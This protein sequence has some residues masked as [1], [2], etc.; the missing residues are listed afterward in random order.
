[1]EKIG[2]VLSGG[3]AKGAYQIGV[4]KALRK[5]K[6]KYDVVTG[7][8]AGALN[9]LLFVQ[10]EYRKAKKIWENIDYNYVFNNP[11]KLNED[12]DNTYA[13]YTTYFNE[14]IKNGGMKVEK[15]EK[16]IE[17]IFNEKKFRS[18]K[19][20]FGI[21]TFN[22][23]KFKPKILKKQE[24]TKDN[25][26]DYISASSCF[27]PAFKLKKIDGMSYI[28][29][30]VYD[31]LPINLCEELG[32]T[33]IIAVDTK[34][35]GVKKKVKNENLEIITIAP[36]NKIIPLL[37]FEKKL[38]IQTMK[39]GY[40]DAMKVFG[41]YFGK[42]FTYKIKPFIKFEKKLKFN[43]KITEFIKEFSYKNE[44]EI[45]EQLLEPELI[46]IIEYT[47]IIFEQQQEKI[48]NIKKY[49]K[50]ILKKLKN[51]NE[52]SNYENQNL[53]INIKSIINQIY[54]KNKKEIQKIIRKTPKEFL[55]A[56]YLYTITKK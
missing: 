28:D 32:A 37:V 23:T 10:N 16:Q 14:A 51:I 53:I 8:S 24:L 39:Y 22:L 48:Y 49:N 55:V 45:I 43:Q 31:N 3:G 4:W 18:S 26:K 21:I 25:I 7:T 41:K 13:A 50:Q 34:A 27:F 30:G 19:V 46:D 54:T 40:N 11:E 33:K 2:V 47:G 12:P 29:G 52:T 42:K 15:L 5:L 38:A 20:D 1:M 9:G 17:K 44:T 35:I 6:I 56:F 36:N